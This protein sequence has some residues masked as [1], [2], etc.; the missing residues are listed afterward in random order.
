MGL[1]CSLEGPGAETELSMHD[2][3][4]RDCLFMEDSLSTVGSASGKVII[5]TAGAGDCRIHVTDC[6]NANIIQSMAGHTGHVLSLCAVAAGGGN[7]SS[8]FASGSGK[9][10]TCSLLKSQLYILRIPKTQQKFQR[11]KSR[12]ISSI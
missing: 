11:Y 12:H 10:H 6:A 9:I 7:P 3:T 5:I 1:G 4:V 8:V 2:G